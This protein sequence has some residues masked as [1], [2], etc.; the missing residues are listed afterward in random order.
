MQVDDT[1]TYETITDE[2]I[3]KMVCDEDDED[4]SIG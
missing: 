1:T 2:D 3:A 4:Y